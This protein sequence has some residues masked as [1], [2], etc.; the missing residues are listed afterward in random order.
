MKLA[1]Y[2]ILILIIASLGLYIFGFRLQSQ[3]INTNARI[4]FSLDGFI[5]ASELNNTN[6]LV[7]KNANFEL[8][9]DE[10]TSYIKVID[11]RNDE[12]WQSNP[13]TP[14]PWQLDPTKPITQDAIDKQKA[15]IELTFFNS[16]GS[17]ATINNYRLSINH[18]QSIF[19][20][21]GQKT[22]KIKYLENKVQ[23]LY[24]LRSLDVDYLYFPKYIAADTYNNLSEIPEL[25]ESDV[26]EI[27]R[28]YSGFDTELNAYFIN[29]YE[30]MS[31]LVKNRLYRVFYDKLN[32]T[33]ER[34]IE[35]NATFGYFEVFE[36]FSFTVGLEIEL[37]DKGIK[38]SIIKDSIVEPESL[39]IAS[40]SLYPLFGTAV[41][42]I[43][44]TPTEGYIVLP[45]GSGAVIEFNNG[46]F[47]QNPYRKRL[48]GQDLS[49]LPLK[50]QE[51]Q[52]KNSFPI[53][54]MI[55]ENHGFAAIITAGDAMAVLNADVSG[56]IDS[57]NKVFPSFF[58]RES[59]SVVLGSGFNSYGFDLW[60][61]D[62]VSTDFTVE[63]HF[64]NED[65]S[66]YIGIAKTY[67]RYLIENKGLEVKDNSKATVLT[68]EFLGAYDRKEFLFG[69]PYYTTNSLTTFDQ[70]EKIIDEFI[71]RNITDMNV[72]FSGVVNGGLSSSIQDRIQ[73]ERVLG[74]K[75]EYNRFLESLNTLNIPVFTQVNTMTASSYR[76]VF[77]SFN[78]SSRRL[79]GQLSR[80]FTY[81][82]PSRLPF[83]ETPYDH[84]G[85]D[86]I[87][88]PEYYNSIFNRLN[89]SFDQDPLFFTFL[90]SRLAGNYDKGNLI[91][92]QDS[93]TLQQELL[94]GMDNPTMLTNPLAFAIPYASFIV[95]LP[96]ET[97]LYSIIDYE[98]PL[99]QLVLSG[100]VDYSTESININNT[101]S[102]RYNF[103]KAIE[104]GSNLKYTLTYNDSRDLIDTQYNF[105]MA[106]HYV[107]WLDIIESQINE[108]N[109]LG[110]HQGHIINHQRVLNNVFLVT[111]S[112]G[113]SIM[114]N[115][116]LSPV[117][118]DG[119]TIPERDYKIWEGPSY[120]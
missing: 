50:M 115:Y 56:R 1:K 23:V 46:K 68:T 36:E 63:Y 40:I 37:F 105:Y 96:V 30:G 72:I 31:R 111:Y 92:L 62:I 65:N 35:E 110:I 80:D 101:R 108:I 74:G 22:F 83:S 13:I 10:L 7:G 77:D 69:V 119:Q 90:G 85:D 18:P 33:R 16:F 3:S 86:Y 6:K 44:D 97:T 89:R 32:Y 4:S 70:A 114:I 117:V 57:Y 71:S 20:A 52:Q 51:Q 100:I 66:S 64:L 104:T 82:Y 21:E 43:N 48:Y 9:I 25:N 17:A 88:S 59:E 41:S 26:L 79:N 29:N 102:T 107:N 39:K 73:I 76:R 8:Y 116:N 12:V 49:L 60:T 54:G 91:Y 38:T 87:I 112:H 78:Y 61:K 15:T 2:V 45:D 19:A 99:L 81:H 94:K 118:I 120:G 67:Q 14:D 109:S 84:R 106:T 28:N 24:T 5:D 93:M 11:L 34:S 55:K 53:Y 98:I 58:L 95:D 42:I 103:L 47:Y 75:R 27:Q 113:L